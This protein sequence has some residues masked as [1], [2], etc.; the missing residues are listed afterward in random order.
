[1]ALQNILPYTT[2]A[3]ERAKTLRKNMT[4]SEKLFWDNVRKNQLGTKF[5]R[6]FPILDYVVDFYVKEI[7]LAIEI[8]GEYH[9]SQ[10]LE[11]SKRQERIE[12]LG[13]QFLRFSNNQINNDLPNVIQEITETIS[14]LQ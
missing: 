9:N 10:F 5:Y 7:G 6:Q 13:V 1:M 12:K 8:D 3:R 4:Q 2:E 11:D 14:E